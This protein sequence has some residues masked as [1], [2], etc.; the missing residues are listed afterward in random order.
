MKAIHVAFMNL[1]AI[2][3]VNKIMQMTNYDKLQGSKIF[4]LQSQQTKLSASFKLS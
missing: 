4:Q 1:W 2:F 3:F